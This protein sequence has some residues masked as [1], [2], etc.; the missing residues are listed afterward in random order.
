[1]PYG[2]L[3]EKQIIALEERIHS[4]QNLFDQE[5]DCT[6][7]KLVY[8]IFPLYHLFYALLKPLYPENTADRIGYYSCESLC[9]QT[10]ENG[11]LT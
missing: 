4:M 11:I 7:R 8:K 10:V 5:E 9:K 1:M 6:F 3:S 2:R